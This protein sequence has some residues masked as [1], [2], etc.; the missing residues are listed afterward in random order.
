MAWCG[1][2]WSEAWRGEAR[3][4]ENSE[5]EGDWSWRRV[6]GIRGCVWRRQRRVLAACVVG[7]LARSFDDC[8]GGAAWVWLNVGVIGGGGGEDEAQG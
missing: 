8:G 6:C 3:R 2:V 7:G 1:T 5:R 4:R